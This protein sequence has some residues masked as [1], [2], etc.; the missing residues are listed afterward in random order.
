VKG[1]LKSIDI[2]I[3]QLNLGVEFD[4]NYWH[5]DKRVLDKL[6]TEKLQEAGFQII[7]IREEP[8]KKINDIDIISPLPYNGKLLTNAVLSRIQEMYSL[9]ADVKRRIAAYKGME[10][11]QNEA[12]LEAYVE[13]ILNEKSGVA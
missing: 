9:P 3:P 2:F 7:R 5:K 1:R 10:G 4:G 6:K 13:Q 12:G 11:L 8:L